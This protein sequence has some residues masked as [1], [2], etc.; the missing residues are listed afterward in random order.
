MSDEVDIREHID[1]LC[2]AFGLDKNDVIRIELEPAF[3]HVHVLIRNSRGRP[4]VDPAG[5]IATQ[6]R[7]YALTKEGTA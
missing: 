3:A 1:A 7:S 2:A 6:V 5:E 4:F